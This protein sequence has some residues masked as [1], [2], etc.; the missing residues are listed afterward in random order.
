MTVLQLIRERTS[1]FRPIPGWIARRF[2]APRILR[3]LR[4]DAPSGAS[5]VERRIRRCRLSLEH[6]VYVGT[7]TQALAHTPGHA[8]GIK[9]CRFDPGS[10]ALTVEGAV[11]GV[12]NPSYLAL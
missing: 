9:R 11:S 5:N 3:H 8:G 6:V 1:T 12:V 7:Y 10:G 2:A 4:N